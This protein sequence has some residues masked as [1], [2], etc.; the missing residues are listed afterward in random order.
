MVQVAR[1]SLQK[2]CTIGSS[3]WFSDPETILNSGP[4][5]WHPAR[6]SALTAIS[7]P[8]RCIAGTR[9]GLRFGEGAA[10]IGGH[11]LHALL[12]LG[13]FALAVRLDLDDVAN[14]VDEIAVGLLQRLE[15]DDAALR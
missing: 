3:T 12:G 1:F 11:R 5:A 4:R 7:R 15:V 13:A 10:K 14:R 8:R 2:S 6:R 9:S